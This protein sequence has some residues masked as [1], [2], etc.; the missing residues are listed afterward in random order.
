MTT[1]EVVKKLDEA[2]DL[3]ESVSGMDV[4]NAAMDMG[5]DYDILV[6]VEKLQKEAER[7]HA[8]LVWEV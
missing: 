6:R 8:E 5:G 2:L 7:L 3:L 1:S 4:N